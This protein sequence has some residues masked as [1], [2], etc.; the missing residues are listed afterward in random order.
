MSTQAVAQTQQERAR[1]P[2]L[3]CGSDVAHSVELQAKLLNY[4]LGSNKSNINVNDDKTVVWLDPLKPVDDS[5]LW[6]IGPRAHDTEKLKPT[7]SRYSWA[8]AARVW[9][10]CP[11]ES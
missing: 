2:A 7:I 10:Q 6:G 11:V 5:D 8:L 1:L 4:F 9:S 3:P